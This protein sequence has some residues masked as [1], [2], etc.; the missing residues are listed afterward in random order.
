MNKLTASFWGLCKHVSWIM[1]EEDREGS[2][3]EVYISDGGLKV[4]KSLI[5]WPWV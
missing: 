4:S 1:R 5:V 2:S 3:P